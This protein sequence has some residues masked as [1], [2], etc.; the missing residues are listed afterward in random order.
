VVAGDSRKP[1]EPG[2]G[3]REAGIAPTGQV[4]AI[5]PDFRKEAF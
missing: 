5:S 3:K 4:T 1:S 2:S